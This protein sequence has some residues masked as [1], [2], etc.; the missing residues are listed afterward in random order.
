MGKKVGLI[1]NTANGANPSAVF[2]CRFFSEY[3]C[4]NFYINFKKRIDTTS[5]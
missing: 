5:G 4:Q 1:K 3:V 2:F